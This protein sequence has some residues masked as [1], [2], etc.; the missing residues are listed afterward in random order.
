MSE[1]V[2][3]ITP[4]VKSFLESVSLLKGSF[5]THYITILYC[6]HM[7]CVLIINFYYTSKINII[8]LFNT[9]FHFVR[10]KPSILSAKRMKLTDVNYIYP[11]ISISS[12]C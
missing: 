11:L 9:I 3:H 8:H 4:I 7:P 10:P 2:S 12:I 6:I 1:L 5:F